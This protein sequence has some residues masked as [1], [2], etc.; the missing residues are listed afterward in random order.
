MK[1]RLKQNIILDGKFIAAGNIVDDELLTEQL[2]TEAV[3][4][5]DL[6]DHG[7]VMLLRDLNYTTCHRDG[8]GFDV[9]RPVMLGAGELVN[10]DQI[11][12]DWQEG[13]D[14]KFGWTPEERRLLQ[15]KEDAEYVKEFQAHESTT[16]NRQRVRSQRPLRTRLHKGQPPL[17]RSASSAEEIIGVTCVADFVSEIMI[18]TP[19]VV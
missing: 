19:N 10:A 5:S 7:K 15:E 11:Q 12:A 4:T 18:R 9:R 8:E 13:K 3:I 6:E 1:V 16:G 2:K 14:Y 17:Y